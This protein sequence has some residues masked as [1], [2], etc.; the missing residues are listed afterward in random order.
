M[1]AAC[2]FAVE[3]DA[4]CLA[5]PMMTSVARNNWCKSAS[6]LY[7]GIA[8]SVMPLKHATALGKLLLDRA[9]RIVRGCDGIITGVA[10]HVF[11]QVVRE[12]IGEHTGRRA[13]RKR[14]HIPNEGRW[15]VERRDG[16]SMALLHFVRKGRFHP[17]QAKDRPDRLAIGDQV[18]DDL[19]GRACDGQQQAELLGPQVVAVAPH[20]FLHRRHHIDH[21]LRSACQLRRC[22]R[23]AFHHNLLVLE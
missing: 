7:F 5:A 21:V 12:A 2:N 10:L 6:P 11:V 15:V 16:C 17:H 18:L 23:R 22:L 20:H 3:M 9:P 1:M 13:L 8:V 4:S 19:R 14:R